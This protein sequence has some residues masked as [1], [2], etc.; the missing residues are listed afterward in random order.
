MDRLPYL[1]API[2]LGCLI[3]GVEVGRHRGGRTFDALRL[4]S[5]LFFLAYAVV[6]VYLQFADLSDFRGGA[7]YWA[8]QFEP[9]H[10]RFIY[11]SLLGVLGYLGLLTGYAICHQVFPVDF[12]LRPAAANPAGRRSLFITALA[13]TILGT[14]ALA[15]YTAS[16]GG[17][18]PLL[19]Q[20]AAFRTRPP[21]ITSWAFLKN[22]A[23]VVVSATM[24]FAGLYALS[25]A[26]RR[27]RQLGLLLAFAWIVSFI[28]L[29]HRAGRLGL[30]AFLVTLPLAR[31]LRR[32]RVDPLFVGGGAALFVVLVLF[33]KAVFSTGTSPE[34]VLSQWRT[35]RDDAM[36]AVNSILL[37]FSFPFMSASNAVATVPEVTPYR[38]FG[39][40]GIAFL[41]LAPQRITGITPPPTVSM[42][43]SAVLNGEGV[44]VDVTSLGYY[45]AGVPG[46]ALATFVF[47][48][49]LFVVDR[50]VRRYMGRES[51]LFVLGLSVIFYVS[52]SFMY[53]DPQIAMENGFPLFVSLGAVICALKLP[54]LLAPA[55]A[56]QVV[57]SG[58]PPGP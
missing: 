19:F 56:L 45:S 33:G 11:G 17:V 58:Q 29:F 5:G 27:R 50:V 57:E 13:L 46:V 14:A 42:V 20:A 52:F 6:P 4:A 9:H 12:A 16:I 3:L 41:Y 54:R 55:P 48:A 47:G 25:V 21:V 37:E 15:W 43:N 10:P 31:A 51:P 39:D 36:Y 49:L 28:L 18:G 1:A 53:G 23:P 32:G 44:P 24:I 40:V 8:I 34:L 22:V 7:W 2:L 35:V 26:P 38:W 30:I